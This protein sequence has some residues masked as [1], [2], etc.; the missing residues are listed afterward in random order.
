MN[1]YFTTLIR[2]LLLAVALAFTGP[3]ADA[4]RHT[5]EPATA[6]TKADATAGY[7]GEAP[8]GGEVIIA[9]VVVV[10]IVLAWVASRIGDNRSHVTG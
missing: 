9:G 7:T 6:R 2:A 1:A 4:A 8:V 3:T 10:V 5:T